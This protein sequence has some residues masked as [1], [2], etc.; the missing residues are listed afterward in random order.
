MRHYTPRQQSDLK[1]SVHGYP[2][3]RDGRA[4]WSHFLSGQA[5][6]HGVKGSMYLGVPEAGGPPLEAGSLVWL[7]P[8]DVKRLNSSHARTI[9]PAGVCLVEDAASAQLLRKMV[10]SFIVVIP[11][12]LKVSLFREVL[13]TEPVCPRLLLSVD[14]RDTVLSLIQSLT[15]DHDRGSVPPPLHLSTVGAFNRAQHALEVAAGACRHWLSLKCFGAIRDE[16]LGPILEAHDGIVANQ[17]DPEWLKILPIDKVSSFNITG[18]PIYTLSNNRID[19]DSLRNYME[20]FYRKKTI[21]YLELHSEEMTG[22]PEME[23]LL[24]FLCIFAY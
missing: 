8:D 23:N 12:G 16:Q 20:S 7:S 14:D 15:D 6:V 5:C 1:I 24:R 11:I 9:Q 19:Y 10:T 21:Q 18:R 3:W 13:P 17:T 4:L 22:T 2:A